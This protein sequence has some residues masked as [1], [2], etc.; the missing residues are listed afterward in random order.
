MYLVALL[1]LWYVW[2]GEA[3]KATSY[4]L[5]ICVSADVVIVC[6][7]RGVLLS[8][9]LEKRTR[10]EQQQ[11]WVVLRW[12]HNTRA[13]SLLLQ[14]VREGN[15]HRSRQVGRDQDRTCRVGGL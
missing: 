11:D 13:S 2:G 5:T 9:G 6:G 14:C 12:R 15:G 8:G 1:V 7:A 3:G 4:N 10:V